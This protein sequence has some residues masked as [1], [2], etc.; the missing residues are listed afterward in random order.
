MIGPVIFVIAGFA[1][2]WALREM[3]RRGEAGETM[4]RIRPRHNEPEQRSPQASMIVRIFRVN[5][6]YDYEQETDD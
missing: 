6:P 4:F 3:Q 1:L 2:I 5:R